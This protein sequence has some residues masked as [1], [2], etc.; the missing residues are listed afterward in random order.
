MSR[1]GTR[2]AQPLTGVI[3]ADQLVSKLQAK[4][5][6]ALVSDGHGSRGE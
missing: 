6:V 2:T 5:L 4:G 3:V 1:E